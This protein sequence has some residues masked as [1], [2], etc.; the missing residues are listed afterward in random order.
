MK[1]FFI[2]LK[3][4]SLLLCLDKNVFGVPLLIMAE[5]T[6]SPLPHII[7]LA[8]NLLSRLAVDSVGIFRKSGMKS[9]I[10][11]LKTQIEKSPEKLDFDGYSVYDV[12]DALKQY[13]RE[14]PEPLLT[15]KLADTFISIHKG[16]FSFFSCLLLL[17]LPFLRFLDMPRNKNYSHT[18]I[19]VRNLSLTKSFLLFQ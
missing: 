19:V 4:V 2:Q 10:D 7:L 1:F 8:L 9:R 3:N 6:G 15:A 12:A 16:M 5:R 13:F 17:Q 18:K 11:K 14:L